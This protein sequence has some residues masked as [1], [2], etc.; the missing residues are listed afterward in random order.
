MCPISSGTWKILYECFYMFLHAILIYNHRIKDDR[1]EKY[2]SF[3][4]FILKLHCRNAMK[5]V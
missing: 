4:I 5:N 2:S 3:I 1:M